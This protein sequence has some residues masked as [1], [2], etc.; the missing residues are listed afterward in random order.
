[1]YSSMMR[2][3]AALEILGKAEGPLALAEI[4]RRLKSSKSGIHGLL[5]ALARSGYV[6]KT[7]GG[8]YS[9]GLKVWEIARSVPTNRLV[10]VAAPV[11]DRLA[12]RVRDGVILGVLSGFDVVYV[13]LVGSPQAVRV[14]AE[15]G[16]RIPAHCT[17]T[18]L[19]LLASQ[20]PDYLDRV[21]PRKLPVLSPET[22]TDHDQLRRELAR[23]AARGYAINRG[24]WNSDVAGIAM[25][26]PA[27]PACGADCPLRRRPALPHDRALDQDERRGPRRRMRGDCRGS[28]ALLSREAIGRGMT[29]PTP[30][31]W[32]IGV[33]VGGTFTDLVLAGRG[34]GVRVFKVPSVAADPSEG[35]L[36]ALRLAAA[37]EGI[38]RSDRLLAECALFVH[39]STVATN[40]V[41]E[42]KGA[43]VAMLTTRGL[44]RFAG[45]PPRRPRE[46]LGP[47]DALS[48]GPGA[49]PSAPAGARTHRPPWARDRTVLGR[50]CRGGARRLSRARRRGDRGLPV[51]QFLERR[52]RSRR[53][54]GARRISAG[55]RF[56]LERDRA[57]HRRVRAVIDGGTERLRRAADAVLSARP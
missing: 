42:G 36:N 41:L 37:S 31:A 19:A 51:Q 30:S 16:Q 23:V 45:D 48:A 33:D 28:A 11:M 50:G 39:G 25:T 17:S 21:L 1:M 46:P 5:S 13:H 52:T 6:I 15:V 55:A 29:E 44:P 12:A 38:C 34:R 3:I 27:N 9:L 32:R 14:H 49:P 8:F 54:R 2:G 53:G 40:T 22:I 20:A 10:Q 24:G 26:I 4:A 56:A 43:R 7:P 47:P 35:V 18:G 57:D